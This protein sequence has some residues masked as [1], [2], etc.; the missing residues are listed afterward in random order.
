MAIIN[1]S[2]LLIYKK[3]PAD[4]QQRTKI[5]IRNQIEP[6]SALGNLKVTNVLDAS[7]VSASDLTSADFTQ[8]TNN[9]LT[10]STVMHNLIIAAAGY[11]SVSS[12]SLVDSYY[13]FEIENVFAGDI[14][15]VIDIINGTG[16]IKDGYLEIVVTRPGETNN[17]Y[18]PIAFSTSASLSITREMRD[19]TNKDSGGWSESLEGLKSFEMTSD[20]LQDFNA[21]LSFREFFD[22]LAAD[23]TV[24]IRFAERGSGQKYEGQAYVS[25]VS[26]DGG[27][28]DNAT[29]SVTLNG[30][31]IL[32]GGT[33]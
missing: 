16:I 23:D 30:T 2:D 31:T 14:D 5:R 33:Y 29:Y 9:A 18:E 11:T 27:V 26:L 12:P 10:I 24:T 15:S 3:S 13:E 22:D 1:A 7:G 32:S 21:D 6:L 17:A 20:A 4:V 19:V 8:G 25:S 28:E